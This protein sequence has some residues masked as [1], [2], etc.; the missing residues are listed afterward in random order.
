MQL[1]VTGAASRYTACPTILA[2]HQCDTEGPQLTGFDGRQSVSSKDFVDCSVGDL[3]ILSQ[4]KA[5]ATFSEELL[6][7]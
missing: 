2:S 5:C 3:T 6:A 7:N 1:A 4:H